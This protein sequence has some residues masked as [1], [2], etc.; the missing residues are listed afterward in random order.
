P[1][2]AERRA[3]LLEDALAIARRD[4]A[5]D[6]GE[7]A[8][9]F[10]AGRGIP[11]DRLTETDL[12][13][14]PEPDRLRLALTSNGHTTAEID[15]SHLLTDTR[16]PGRIIGAWHDHHRHIITLWART[17]DADD[18]P[19]YLYL[20]GAPRGAGTPYGLSDLP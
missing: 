2:A 1:T 3:R 16:W 6:R 8:R 10:L 14:M 20:R 7:A 19:R 5:G 15:A 18:E 4:L 12:G 11:P 9:R 13:L 17:I